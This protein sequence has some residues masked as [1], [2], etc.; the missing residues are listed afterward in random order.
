M[1]RFINT[2]NQGMDQDSSK[3]KYDNTHYYE[4]FNARIVS[5]EGLSGGAL[6]NMLGNLNRLYSFT[7]GY[8]I[9]YYVLRDHIILWTTVN[10]TSVP[11]PVGR[12]DDKIWK[13][14]IATL[15]DL[16]TDS[17]H[18]L[19]LTEF[20]LGGNLIYQ[21]GL[22]FCTGNPIKA[23][24]RY[25]NANVQKVYWV[26]D[27]NNLRHANLVHDAD[28]NDLTNMSVDKFEVISN[29]DFSQPV[30]ENIVGGNLR[31]GKIQYTYQLY[32]L[33][34]SETAFSP[35]SGL[36]NLTSY[37]DTLSG[38]AAYRGSDLD[39]A[40]GKAV[41]CSITINTAGYTRARIVAVHYTSLYGDPEI[42]IV[43]EREI[44]GTLDE[45]FTFTDTEQT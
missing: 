26:D 11:D 38:S 29:I 16:T 19:S 8:I 10:Q 30:I 22:G 44:A 5:Q 45:T 40:T 6:E 39:D 18:T 17:Y 21:G 2:F 27:Y 7:Y 15:E 25:E 42:R 34:G 13:V 31:S 41:Q 9:G 23:I 36:V 14:P 33:H 37:S 3:N 20:H 43:E 1:A 4:A 32:T 35:L 28:T 12:P 24:G